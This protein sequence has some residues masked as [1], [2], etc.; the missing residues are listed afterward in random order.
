MATQI[1]DELQSSVAVAI[2]PASSIALPG[3]RKLTLAVSGM[4]CASC[5]RHV[6]RGL[7]K[8]VGVSTASVNLATEQAEVSYDPA[9]VTIE[10]MIEKVTQIGYGARV[11]YEEQARPGS[12]ESATAQ[13]LELRIGGMTCASCVRH[14]ERALS[15]VAGVEAA[16]VN[17]ATER[18]TV[19]Y[20]PSRIGVDEL[21]AA[22][23]KAGYT[24]V[25]LAADHEI[26]GEAAAAQE[27]DSQQERNHL[28][29]D[30][31]FAA[32]LTIP[33]FVISMFL[34]E[35]LYNLLGV[36]LNYLLF[37]ITLPVWLGSGW[38]FHRSA[39]QNIRHGNANM[40]VL[41]SIGTTAAF[42]YSAYNTFFAPATMSGMGMAASHV[43]YDTTAVIVTL[44]LLGR[45]LE[46]AARRRTTEA[47]K[48]LA[49][50]Q[51]KTARVLRR[52]DWLEVPLGEVLP[53]DLL[54]VRPGERVPTDGVVAEGRSAV[55]ESMITG[56]SLPVDKVAGAKVY[57]A[58]INR[59]GALQVRATAVGRRTVL[60]Q[61]VRLVEEA[62]GSKAPLQDLADKV[63]GVFVPIV[64]V[65]AALTFLGWLLIG[66]NLA[67]AVIN[68]VAVLVI[69]CPCAMGLATPTAIMVGTGR[70]AQAGILVKG[71]RSL[72]AARSLTAIVLDKT[73]TVTEGKP[74]LTDVRTYNGYDEAAALSIAVAVERNSEHPVAQA[75]VAGAQARSTASSLSSS[76]FVALPGLGVQATVGG[77]PVLVGSPTLISEQGISLDHD[78]LTYLHAL[79]AEGKT[80]LLL[81]VG[82]KLAALLAVA[83]TIKP[84]AAIAVA[85]MKR[86]GLKVV[87]LTGDNQRTA[88][89]IARQAGIDEVVAEVLPSQK[90]AEVRRLQAAGY[91]VAM[92][93]DGINDA[94]ALATA[95]LGVAIGTGTDVA[96]AASD[97]T[98]VGGDLRLVATAIA[99]SQ[100][101]VRAIKGNLF[102]A[103][104]YNVVGI[105][106]AV[107]GLLNPIIAAGAM[108]FSSIF[109]VGNSLRLRGVKLTAADKQA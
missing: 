5:V 58:T 96:I 99:L 40:D 50:L 44:I 52:G 3:A 1:K 86:L 55:D 82:G 20:D 36:W 87:M 15:K 66:G 74:S 108:A 4:T 28:R 90:A 43:Y 2:E 63:A 16:S 39:V 92:V 61:I 69:A 9:A 42:L 83:D 54:L 95:D 27:A 78:L 41:V 94:P 81:A 106:L 8:L 46:S 48:K 105:P 11:L 98:L 57:G 51:A 67:A 53:G 31:I 14:V 103:F 45:Y 56:E 34:M 68:A 101:T 21:Q 30:L 29:R 79:Q 25:L 107:L 80:V 35:P 84:Q 7:A 104:L 71:G 59:E 89:T 76:D 62:Q 64:L 49:G 65:V 33:I 75:V 22:I 32:A 13:Q 102:W 70:G 93:G 100:A 12:N 109:V 10:Q 91:K 88:A 85:E 77:Q 24:A 47:V 60:A 26:G 97:I 19:S 72:E 37:A 18:A 23:E 6:E 73:G 38:R 17:L